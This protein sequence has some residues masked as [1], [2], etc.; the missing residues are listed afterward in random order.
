MKKNSNIRVFLTLDE[1]DTKFPALKA[2]TKLVIFKEHG[3]S[4]I[5][6]TIG[7]SDEIYEDGGGWCRINDKSF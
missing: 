6:R 4:I 2:K 7:K 1:Y 3:Q 5:F